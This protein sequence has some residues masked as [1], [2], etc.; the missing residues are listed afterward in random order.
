MTAHN[1]FAQWLLDMLEEKG[2]SQVVLSERSGITQTHISRILSGDRR[3]GLEFYEGV[4]RAFRVPM[5]EVLRYAGVLPAL[6]NTDPST[7]GLLARLSELPPSLRQAT[8]AV[9]YDVLS[10]LSHSLSQ[11]QS[12]PSVA[13]PIQFHTREDLLAWVRSLPEEE[14]SDLLVAMTTTFEPSASKPSSS[15]R[16]NTR[17]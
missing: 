4:A 8:L 5:E 2:W 1:K 14:Q 15:V 13:P 3:P 7:S 16:R 17:A 9:F 12:S 10:L 11:A 6:P